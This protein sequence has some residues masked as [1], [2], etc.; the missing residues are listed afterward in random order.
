MTFPRDDSIEVMVRNVQQWFQSE[1]E[2]ER[3][4]QKTEACAFSVSLVVH[5]VKM[6][7]RERSVSLWTRQ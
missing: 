1:Q 7:L 6:L 2:K 3:R 5:R 4:I